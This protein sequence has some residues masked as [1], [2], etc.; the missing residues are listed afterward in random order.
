[1]AQKRNS[2]DAAASARKA[3]F[4]EQ[5]K[6]PGFLGGLWNKSDHSIRLNESV[7]ADS[8]DQFH[9]RWSLRQEVGRAPWNLGG[10]H[11]LGHGLQ[12]QRCY[13]CSRLS[14]LCDGAKEFFEGGVLVVTGNIY[15]SVR[16][17]GIAGV[18]DSFR[19]ELLSGLFHICTVSSA[20]EHGRIFILLE[21]R[22]LMI[23]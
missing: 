13:G 17:A 16:Q 8:F 10:G 1:M 22:S 18:P 9:Q 3:S 5:S 20:V 23:L 15:H 21:T 7:V 14:V 2:S 19:R 12:G 4:A 11:V 6:T